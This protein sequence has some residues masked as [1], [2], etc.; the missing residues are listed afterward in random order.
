MVL[1]RRGSTGPEVKRIQQQL[2]QKGYYNGPIDGIYG[3]GTESSVRAFQRAEELAVDGVVGPNTWKELFDED[4]VSPPS[5]LE[6][7]LSFRSLALTG[8]FETGKPTPDCFAGI[9]GD[10]DGQGISFGAMQWNLGQGSL[11]PLLEK[12]DHQHPDLV[13]DIFADRCSEFREILKAPKEQQM[14]WSRSI[15]N[16]NNFVLR[17]P[18]GGLFKTLGRCEEFQ[19]IEVDTAGRLYDEAIELARE[20]D[21]RSERAVTLMFDIKVQNGSIYPYVKHQIMRDFDHLPEDANEED[22]LSIVANRRAEACKKRWIEDV[23]R[24]KLTIARGRGTVHGMHYEL[25]EDYGI[26]LDS[27]V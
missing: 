21:L 22:R 3:G 27:E 2:Q 8:T 18:W 16:Q 10:F 20:Y 23:R 1:Y 19:D 13:G 6:E 12:M 5:I 14:A 7:P 25:K 4:A 11:Q 26:R 9:S 17:E 15:Q 24:R